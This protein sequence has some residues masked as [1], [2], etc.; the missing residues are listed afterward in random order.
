MTIPFVSCD[1]TAYDWTTAEETEGAGEDTRPGDTAP[2][3][4]VIDDIVV[5]AITTSTA[6]LRIYVADGE[7]GQTYVAQWRVQGETSWT[8]TA[9]QVTVDGSPFPFFE[10]GVVAAE[11][12]DVQIALQTPG[13]IPSEWSATFSIDA[14]PTTT[15]IIYDGN[16]PP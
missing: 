9:E 15:E 1:P 7:P 5:F 6:R 11:L 16:D 4:P 10:T 2:E 8:A 14:S 3:A 13:G 12:L